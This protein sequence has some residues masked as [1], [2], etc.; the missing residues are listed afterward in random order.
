MWVKIGL[1]QNLKNGITYMKY[2]TSQSRLLHA[3][4]SKHGGSTVLSKL[5]GYPKQNFTNWKIRGKVPLEHVG[6]ISTDLEE[7]KW[8]FNYEE[9]QTLL[10]GKPDWK[11]LVQRTFNDKDTREWV[12][13]GSWPYG[14]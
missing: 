5:T 14:S 9:L 12:L 13:E 11:V 2:K 7:S 3:V 6:K 10:D 1:M 8:A 4:F